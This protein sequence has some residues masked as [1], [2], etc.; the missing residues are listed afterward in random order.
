MMTTKVLLFAL[1]LAATFAEDMIVTKAYTDYLKKHASWRVADYESNVFRGW[2]LSEAQLFLGAIL[3]SSSADLASVATA[4]NLPS[5]LSWAHANCDHG[6]RN[7]GSCGTCWAFATAGMLSERCC[8]QGHDHGWLAPQELV[9]CD[10]HNQGCA[11]GWPSSALDYVISAKGIVHE[12]CF[13]YKAANAACPSVCADAKDWT[14]SHVCN[15]QDGYKSF[16]TDAELKS[17]IQS[18]PVTVTFG[19]CRSFFSYEADVYKCD[20]GGKYLGVHTAL[21][22]GYSDAP[23]CNYQV[24]NSWG[25]NWGQAGYIS[26]GCGQCGIPS[27]YPSGNVFCDSVSP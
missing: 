22:M 18:G 17:V 10:P 15:C 26:I 25:S 23:E 4:K 21:V 1:L 27:A 12:E 13:P 14:G 20:C 6:P 7:Q 5:R 16:R 9:S 3:P 2:T 19:V 24:R 11:G 8:L